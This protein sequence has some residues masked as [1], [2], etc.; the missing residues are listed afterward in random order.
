MRRIVIWLILV[1]LI[2]SLPASAQ[3]LTTGVGPGGFGGGT[4]LTPCTS[5]GIYDL[6]NVC[7]DIYFIGAL[8]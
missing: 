5:T 3:L 6:S 7:N 8:K 1:L 4:I 2:S